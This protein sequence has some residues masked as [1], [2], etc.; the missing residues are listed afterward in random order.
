MEH[1]VPSVPIELDGKQHR[2]VFDFNAQAV[3]EEATGVTV[4]SLFDKKGRLKI[5]SRFTRAL[6]WSQLLHFDEQVQFDE[7]GRIAEPPALSMQHIGKLITQQNLKEVNSKTAEALLLF[8]RPAK[9]KTEA[10]TEEKNPP[11]R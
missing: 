8:F 4:L 3:F 2:L 6:L 11:S 7:F 10:E 1:I 9:A 5:S